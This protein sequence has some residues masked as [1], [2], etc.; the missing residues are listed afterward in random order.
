MLPSVLRHVTPDMLLIWDRN[1]FS[2]E[3]WKTLN[4]REIKVLA[5]VK[6][7]LDPATD[8]ASFRRLLLGQDLSQRLCPER[9]TATASWCG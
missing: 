9:K 2:Y 3:L 1:F 6:A 7:N 4:S 8:P 5:R